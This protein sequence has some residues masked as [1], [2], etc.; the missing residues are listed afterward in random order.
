MVFKT[1]GTGTAY[2]LSHECK[3]L[4]YG[5]EE[6]AW[7]SFHPIVAPLPVPL[8]FMFLILDTTSPAQKANRSPYKRKA[9]LSESVV[10]R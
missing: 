8:C 6:G 3:L 2:K 5:R 4:A 7:L 9:C 10:R 1:K